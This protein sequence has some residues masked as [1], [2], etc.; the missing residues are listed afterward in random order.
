[1]GRTLSFHPTLFCTLN[2]S[3]CLKT[4]LFNREPSLW[5]CCTAESRHS[6]NL[7][8]DG[9]KRRRALVTRAAVGS[10]GAQGWGGGFGEEILQR[11]AEEPD[12]LR[13]IGKGRAVVAARRSRGPARAKAPRRKGPMLSAPERTH[14]TF[15][16]APRRPGLSNAS[17]DS[18][19]EGPWG[20][21][22]SRPGTV[23]GQ[24]RRARGHSRLF[25]RPRPEAQL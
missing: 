16:F 13:G 11:E 25:Q 20:S 5:T 3:V 15:R 1:M 24:G 14:P 22:G 17:L 12:V 6:G 21:G 9:V 19:R 2:Y 4:F 8:S 18:Q 7:H 10:M 23:L